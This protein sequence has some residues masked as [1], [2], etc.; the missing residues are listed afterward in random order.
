MRIA[1]RDFVLIV[2]GC[3]SFALT[4]PISSQQTTTR[5]S[6]R[7]LA[8]V[9]VSVNSDPI[10]DAV[11]FSSRREHGVGRYITKE[12]LARKSSFRFTDLLRTIPG[13][14][15]GI[16]KYGDNVVSSPRSGGSV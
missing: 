1:S 10:L 13:L 3:A 5:D 8:P 6:A 16:N 7:V 11:G 15:V 12:E 9:K 2:G 4:G 14:R